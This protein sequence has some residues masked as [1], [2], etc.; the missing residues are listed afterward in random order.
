[1][2]KKTTTPPRRPKAKTEGLEL[3]LN[4]PVVAPARESAVEV[5]RATVSAAKP[6]SRPVESATAVKKAVRK[7]A[8]EGT[9]QAPARES[10]V[11]VKRATVGA[12]K[13]VSRPVETAPTVDKAERKTAPKRAQPAPALRPAAVQSQPQGQPASKPQ[14]QPASKP[15]ENPS[16][17]AGKKD[18]IAEGLELIATLETCSAIAAKGAE[19]LGKEV[20][21]LARGSVQA[22][23][24]LTE[25]L[26][27]AKTLP[28]A[29][30]AQ[31]NFARES[32]GNMT[33]GFA[34]LT[35]MSMELTQIFMA[36]I[37]ARVSDTASSI[38]QRAA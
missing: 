15:F 34:K 5:K 12:A 23:F 10:A 22:Q 32:L 13:P 21:S 28:E 14:G 37:Q 9:Q 36:P 18:P 7:T 25:A 27:N 4:K 30:T 11:E 33:E 19:S 29:L 20:V 8:A 1:M 17:A 6:A 3:P 38:W 31:G 2:A 24:A 26:M 16:K 35:G